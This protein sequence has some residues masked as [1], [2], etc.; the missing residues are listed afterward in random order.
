MSFL[1]KKLFVDRILKAS[2][3]WGVS[4]VDIKKKMRFYWWNFNG[5]FRQF[6]FSLGKSF[7]WVGEHQHTQTRLSRWGFNQILPKKNN[8]FII[9]FHYISFWTLQDERTNLLNNVLIT[10]LFPFKYFP[11][12]HLSILFLTFFLVT[13]TSIKMDDTSQKNKHS[14]LPQV[15][16]FWASVFRALVWQGGVCVKFANLSSH[17][18][19]SAVNCEFLFLPYKAEDETAETKW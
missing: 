19:S 8:D 13:L 11:A 14:R 12:S 1:R 3:M 7:H 18:K 5:N 15:T 16:S 4:A 9:Y 6:K 17:A 10:F 2:T